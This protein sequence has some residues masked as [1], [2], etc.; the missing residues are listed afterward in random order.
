MSV[1]FFNIK[2]IVCLSTREMTKPDNE[3]MSSKC[4]H[5]QCTHYIYIFF[6]GGIMVDVCVMSSLYL[7]LFKI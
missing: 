6:G 3:T 2:T 7:A 1:S 5:D 4:N